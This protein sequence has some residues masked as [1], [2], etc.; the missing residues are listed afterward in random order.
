M[1]YGHTP[2]PDGVAKV[3]SGTF[4]CS[5]DG[6][7]Q[8][9]HRT[10]LG[11]GIGE[12]QHMCGGLGLDEHVRDRLPMALPMANRYRIAT[13]SFECEHPVLLHSF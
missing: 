11:I 3:G 4:P 2:N 9:R 13:E 12:R 6:Y 8:A 7:P 1:I 10:S 5:S